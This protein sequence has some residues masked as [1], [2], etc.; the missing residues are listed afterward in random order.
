MLK[1][2]L[3]CRNIK[4][5]EKQ[6]ELSEQLSA[7]NSIKNLECFKIR[8][9]TTI[10]AMTVAVEYN[11]NSHKFI[12][13]PFLFSI[14]P[15]RLCSNVWP[16]RSGRRKTRTGK[17]MGVGEEIESLNLDLKHLI[18]FHQPNRCDVVYHLGKANDPLPPSQWYE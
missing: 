12:Y 5:N 4:K 1:K 16:H 10:T 18:G 14:T 3:K 17:E 2:N 11:L 7:L 13:C 9:L 8:K 6:L 15:R